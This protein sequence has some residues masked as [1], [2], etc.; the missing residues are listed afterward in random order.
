MA[1]SYELRPEAPTLDE[2]PYDLPLNLDHMPADY[3]E[4]VEMLRRAK[5]RLRAIDNAKWMPEE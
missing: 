5:R 1:G 4:A 3:A 2:S